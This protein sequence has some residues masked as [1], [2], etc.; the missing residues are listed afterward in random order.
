MFTIRASQ[1][2]FDGYTDIHGGL[3]GNG[4]AAVVTFSAS[5]GANN[6][7]DGRF[8]TYEKTLNGD[9]PLNGIRTTMAARKPTADSIAVGVS[10]ENIDRYLADD[11]EFRL[12]PVQQRTI[13]GVCKSAEEVLLDLA[14][15]TL[16][17]FDRYDHV[18][19]SRLGQH[20]E[21][22]ITGTFVQLLRDTGSLASGDASTDRKAMILKRAQDIIDKKYAD[23]LT[24]SGVAAAVG[25]SQR[26]LQ[27]AFQERLNVT[28]HQYLRTVRLE[29]ARAMLAASGAINV[30]MVAF[31]CG[32]THLGRF[33]QIYHGRF[34]ELPSQTLRHARQEC[35]D[36]LNVVL[37]GTGGRRFSIDACLGNCHPKRFVG[38]AENNRR[39]SQ[40]LS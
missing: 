10:L 13:N 11:R 16:N 4:A 40:K 8:I 1:N 14:I 39:K 9:P 28:P 3:I 37:D 31:D 25:T 33:A 24:I 18:A 29:R 6:A 21:D 19:A 30:T 7:R 22:L 35:P 17:H 5:A 20:V 32:F 26:S 38:V 36:R 2:M 12:E 27:M 15:H 23:Q 34:G